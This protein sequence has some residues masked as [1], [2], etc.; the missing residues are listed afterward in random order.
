MR[1]SGRAG[2]AHEINSGIPRR[3]LQMMVVFFFFFFSALVGRP[4]PRF[5]LVFASN[6]VSAEEAFSGPSSKVGCVENICC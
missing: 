4:L 1:A 2:G 3:V 5:C 6:P